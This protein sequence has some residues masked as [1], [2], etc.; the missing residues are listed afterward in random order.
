MNNTL[1][2]CQIHFMN[3]HLIPMMINLGCTGVQFN[4]SPCGETSY[5]EWNDIHGKYQCVDTTGMTRKEIL[6]DVADIMNE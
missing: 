6:K 2:L 4:Q 5:L 1:L 3:K